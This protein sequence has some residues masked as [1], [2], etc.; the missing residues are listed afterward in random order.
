MKIHNNYI[1]LADILANGVAVLLILIAMSLSVKQQEFGKEVEQISN[2]GSVMSRDIATS[3][4]TNALPSSRPGV[5]HDY[6]H[7]R[8]KNVP[9]IIM[10]KKGLL[11]VSAGD[12]KLV[13]LSL[14]K[15]QLLQKNNGFDQ[16]L[17]RLKPRQRIELRAD[18][19]HIRHYY[20]IMSILKQHKLRIMHW[21]FLGDETEKDGFLTLNEPLKEPEFQQSPLNNLPAPKGSI[22]LTQAVD[23]FISDDAIEVE[24]IDGGLSENAESDALKHEK[25]P[26]TEKLSRFT[27]AL[28]IG[29]ADGSVL[30]GKEMDKHQKQQKEV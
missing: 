12:G 22:A 13:N 24:N 17:Q 23:F 14:T 10:R 27:R 5:L 1:P 19:R 25:M 26:T 7:P 28:N 15:A 16:F 18:V 30:A 29:F 21:H 3:L 9:R 11:I 8:K 4:I 6:N 20:L 2:I